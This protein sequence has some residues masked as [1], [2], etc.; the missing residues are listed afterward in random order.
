MSFPTERL[1]FCI[2]PLESVDDTFI[3]M[4]KMLEKEKHLLVPTAKGRQLKMFQQ[5][6]FLV[7]EPATERTYYYEKD[8][9]RK[10]LASLETPNFIKDAIREVMKELQKRGSGKEPRCQ[11]VK[12]KFV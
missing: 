3:Y 2:A 8:A 10:I 5:K 7:V 6:T 9:S 4:K 12:K 1:G 11:D